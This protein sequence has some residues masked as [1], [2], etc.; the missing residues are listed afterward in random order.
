ME[1]ML[2]MADWFQRAAVGTV[3]C[4]FAGQPTTNDRATG[5]HP[6]YTK[7]VEYFDIHD[8]VHG[9]TFHVKTS[10]WLTN[11]ASKPTSDL[12]PLLK[13]DAFEQHVMKCAHQILYSVGAFAVH[14]TFT[15]KCPTCGRAHTEERT[16]PESGSGFVERLGRPPNYDG[17]HMD[18]WR[19]L[20]RGDRLLRFVRVGDREWHWS[21]EFKLMI[22]SANGVQGG[23]P[24]YWRLAPTE[25]AP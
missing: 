23:R 5:P 6:D 10:I 13:T 2:R 12:L 16:L 25:A 21:S 7:K 4:S 19:L 3:V 9:P 14:E 17:D 24:Y 11:T 1:P 20:Y 22:D 18:V 15:E 8:T